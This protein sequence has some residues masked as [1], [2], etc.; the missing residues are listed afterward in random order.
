MY[1]EGIGARAGQC[2]ELRVWGRKGGACKRECI[3][4]GDRA[5]RQ[6]KATKNGLYTGQKEKKHAEE[7]ED[8]PTRSH[9]AT[10]GTGPGGRRGGVGSVSVR[11]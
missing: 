5:A 7:Q 11:K 9:N 4:E 8:M 6:G 10:R 1:V 2:H 3:W